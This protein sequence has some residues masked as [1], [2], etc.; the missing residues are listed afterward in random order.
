MD[1]PAG[2]RNYTYAQD[3]AIFRTKTHWFLLLVLLAFL[4]TAPVWFNGY[5][6]SIANLIG[7]T[8]IAVT[9]LNI[10]TG[11]CGQLSIGQAG[12]MAVGAYTSAI[13][14]GRFNLPF[15]LAMLSA[16]LSAGL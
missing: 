5:W 12:F 2:T 7:I 16:G 11:Y 15:P 4:F 14:V 9:G 1:L 10:L 3:M 13:L 8:I 6:L